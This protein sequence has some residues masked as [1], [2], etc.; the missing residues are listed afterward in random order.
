[1]QQTYHCYWGRNRNITQM[2]VL[3]FAGLPLINQF[4]TIED[5]RVN[6]ALNGLTPL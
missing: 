3:V 5:K 6:E 1:M 4:N 2:G